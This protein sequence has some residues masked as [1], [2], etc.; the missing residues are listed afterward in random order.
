MVSKCRQADWLVASPGRGLSGTSWTEMTLLL[1][2]PSLLL[3]LLQIE[4]ISVDYKTFDE[5]HALVQKYGFKKV[6]EAG[7]EAATGNVAA[8]ATGT[9]ASAAAT[10]AE[11]K[12][13]GS[14]AV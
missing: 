2:L 10:E 9:A 3:L 4:R 12:T 11:A 8:A 7:A 1:L 14:R 6:P 5:M 13:E